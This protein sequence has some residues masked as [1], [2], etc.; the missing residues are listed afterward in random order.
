MPRKAKTATTA[1]PEPQTVTVSPAPPPAPAPAPAQPIIHP[2]SFERRPLPT[3]HI[4][5]QGYS[6]N[7]DGTLPTSKDGNGG[8]YFYIVSRPNRGGTLIEV[9]RSDATYDLITAAG[10]AAR[11][12]IETMTA[13]TPLSEPEDEGAVLPTTRIQRDD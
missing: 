9:T 2:W 7:V 3:P 12:A 5:H 13:I 4:K 8:K 10:T 11:K 6:Y 1:A